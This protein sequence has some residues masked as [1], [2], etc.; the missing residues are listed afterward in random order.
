MFC[1]NTT[2]DNTVV[3]CSILEYTVVYCSILKYTVVRCIMFWALLIVH[4]VFV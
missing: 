3:Y 2:L 1:D 4:F